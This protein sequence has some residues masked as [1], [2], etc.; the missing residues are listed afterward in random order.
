M[1]PP[2]DDDGQDGTPE[3]VY[4]PLETPQAHAREIVRCLELLQADFGLTLDDAC[5]SDLFV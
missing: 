5:A 3:E 2:F 1:N 4:G